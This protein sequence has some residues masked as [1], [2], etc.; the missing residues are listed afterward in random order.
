MSGSHHCLVGMRKRT[1][2]RV[3]GCEAGQPHSDSRGLRHVSGWGKVQTVRK[4]WVPPPQGLFWGI[5]RNCALQE[6]HG[7]ELAQ[8]GARE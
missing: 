6:A 5:T 3:R 7:E 8:A 4:G 1:A 2:T